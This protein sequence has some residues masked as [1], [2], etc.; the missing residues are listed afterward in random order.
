ML[1]VALTGTA[2][3]VR[4]LRNGEVAVQNL[5][6]DPSESSYR[7]AWSADPITAEQLSDKAQD[8]LTMMRTWADEASSENPYPYA[9]EVY[10]DTWQEAETFWG[11]S[12]PNPLEKQAWLESISYSG[13]TGDLETRN[14]HCQLT[15]ECDK[16]GK[17]LRIH[18]TAGYD[19]QGVYLILDA[20]RDTELLDEDTY[21]HYWEQ[22]DVKFTTEEYETGS[23]QQ[24]VILRNSNSGDDSM[25]A[26]FVDKNVTY[27]I[28]AYRNYAFQEVSV[29]ETLKKALDCF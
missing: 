23:G 28:R 2:V 16:E 29:L 20:I 25:E 5:V 6:S 22:M 10:Q 14:E 21:A 12:M 3:A 1:V 15:M 17:L 24:A 19:C 8:V 11:L 13:F 27:R 7:I 18:T 26:Y 9:W 4:V